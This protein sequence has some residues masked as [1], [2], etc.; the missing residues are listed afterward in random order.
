M[1][2]FYCFFLQRYA[3]G[4]IK[5]SISKQGCLIG[6]SPL[7]STEK[8]QPLRLAFFG[9]GAAS[10]TPAAAAAAPRGDW[11]RPPDPRRRPPASECAGS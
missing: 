6:S 3:I 1:D 5:S 2:G 8:G 9:G 11:G 10:L 4:T 7:T